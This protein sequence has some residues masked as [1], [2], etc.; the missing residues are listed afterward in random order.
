M[1]VLSL[2]AGEAL[3]HG[4]GLDEFSCHHNQK[5][6]EYHCHEGQLTNWNSFKNLKPGSAPIEGK[7]RIVDGDT[8][9][10]I[11]KRIRLHGIDAPERGQKCTRKGREYACGESA[12]D[13]LARMVADQ[14]VTCRSKDVGR[15]GRIVAVCYLEGGR[16]NI[17]ARMVEQG[18]ALAYR[19]YSMDYVD[20]ESAAKALQEGIWAGEFM[21]PWVWRRYKSQ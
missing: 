4:G 20:E 21:E 6:G 1:L 15:Y 11:G 13:A 9:E 19:R 8:L 3:A 2:T 17:N 7:P 18:W 5:R 12:T 16:I 14:Q 10:I